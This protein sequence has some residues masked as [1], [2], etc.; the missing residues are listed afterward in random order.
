MEEKKVDRKSVW[1][2]LIEVEGLDGNP[3]FSKGEKA[4]VNGLVAAS[5]GDAAEKQL[6]KALRE[7]RFHVVSFEDTERWEN[8]AR[9]CIGEHRL[10]ALA[11]FASASGK[12]Q[13]GTFHTWEEQG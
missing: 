9:D 3:D 13:F 10:S 11:E 7:L 5:S 2:T 1:I 4:F 8:R 12:P 6:H